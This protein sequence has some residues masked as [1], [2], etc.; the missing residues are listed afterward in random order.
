MTGRAKI[1]GERRE[2][3]ISLS[4]KYL[5]SKAIANSCKIKY[6]LYNLG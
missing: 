4:K 2:K 5:A 3:K 6:N 1:P